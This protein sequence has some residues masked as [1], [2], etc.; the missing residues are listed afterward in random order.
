[1][2]FTAM[3]DFRRRSL[4]VQ[5][6]WITAGTVSFLCAL[7]NPYIGW[8][9]AGNLAVLLSGFYICRLARQRTER[10]LKNQKM[11]RKMNRQQKENFLRLDRAET[12]NLQAMTHMMLPLL[13]FANAALNVYCY[14]YYK[15]AGRIVAPI[16]AA[17]SQPAMLMVL[18]IVDI[19]GAACYYWF[20][21]QNVGLIMQLPQSRS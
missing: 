10:L 19:A 6:L 17:S 3:K 1:M 21:R 18:L 14:I 11:L 20:V 9:A 13:T 12:K 15:A 16:A 5:I 7:L 2:D 4:T 8:F